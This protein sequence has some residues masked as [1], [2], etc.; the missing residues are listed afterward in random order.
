MCNNFSLL[1]APFKNN[2]SGS[3]FLLTMKSAYFISLV[4]P[5]GRTMIYPLFI[6]PLKQVKAT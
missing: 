6:V 1:D 5:T 3:V 4:S 2:H